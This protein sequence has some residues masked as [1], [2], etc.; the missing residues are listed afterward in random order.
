MVGPRH[1][2]TLRS[3]CQRSN[4]NLNSRVHILFF[5]HLLFVHIYPEVKKWKDNV[6]ELS[7]GN[8]CAI[9]TYIRP[10]LVCLWIFLWFRYI[11]PPTA[12]LAEGAPHS[13][14]A[15]ISRYWYSVHFISLSCYAQVGCSVMSSFRSEATAE[16]SRALVLRSPSLSPLH[17]ARPHLHFAAVLRQTAVRRRVKPRPHQQQ[18]RSSVRLCRKN[19]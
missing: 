15:V 17:T 14:R 7:I 11:V 16:S 1:A 3:E 6:T 13:S 4:F 9:K 19:R 18:C 5:A 8:K 12:R 2:L 10:S